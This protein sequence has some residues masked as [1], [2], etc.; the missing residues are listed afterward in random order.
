MLSV[1]TVFTM[2]RINLRWILFCD[3]ITTIT[4]TWKL[5]FEEI[6]LQRELIL[7]HA[8]IHAYT[9]LTL[10]VLIDPRTHTRTYTHTHTHAGKQAR[11]LTFSKVFLFLHWLIAWEVS[12]ETKPC[13][14]HRSYKAQVTE[15]WFLSRV[16]AFLTLLCTA[17]IARS[18]TLLFVIRN[19]SLEWGMR[20]SDEAWEK[21]GARMN[22]GE[23]R[24]EDK[25]KRRKNE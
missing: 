19:W 20:K 14:I 11:A 15:V 16:E 24:D 1:F 25:R 22:E 18:C 3:W 2:Y 5:G 21:G 9:D 7:Q 13:W 8:H 10:A 6:S 12:I 17:V 4:T 23:R